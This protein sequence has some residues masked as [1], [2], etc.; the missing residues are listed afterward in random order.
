MRAMP[1]LV[2]LALSGAAVAQSLPEAAA[3]QYGSASDPATS[4]AANPHELGFIESPPHLVLTWQAPKETEG[5][6]QVTREVF[7]LESTEATSFFL[8]QEGPYRADPEGQGPYWIL[9]LTQNPA[10]Y[11]WRRPDW[12]LVRCEDQQLRCEN[13]TS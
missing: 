4:C 12:P 5:A 10:G 2:F 6:G 11:C 9:Q 13:A 8:R 1:F 7:D 3:G